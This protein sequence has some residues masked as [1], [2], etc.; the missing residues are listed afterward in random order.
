L[1]PIRA[2]RQFSDTNAINPRFAI[3]TLPFRRY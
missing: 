2:T 3:H 1:A